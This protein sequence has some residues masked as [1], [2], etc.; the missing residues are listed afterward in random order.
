MIRHLYNR[1]MAIILSTWGLSMVLQQVL[2]LGFGA[3]PQRVSGPFTGAI[4]IFGATYP[5]YRLALIVFSIVIISGVYAVFR[6]SRFGLDV[7]AIIQNRD[8]ASALGIDTRSEEHTSEL[9]SLMRI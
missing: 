2:Q 4:D 1:P 7:R 3:A 6:W 9:K 8:M 5:A